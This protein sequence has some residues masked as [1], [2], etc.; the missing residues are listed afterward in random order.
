MAFGGETPALLELDEAST[1]N[2]ARA[3][4][5]GGTAVVI[6]VEAPGDTPFVR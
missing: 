2:G 6:E 4:D 5:R 3:R 1:G